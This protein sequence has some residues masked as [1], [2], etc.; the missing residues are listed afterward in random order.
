MAAV[1]G[2]E[3]FIGSHLVEALVERGSRV[4]A[5][6]QYN[7][8]NSWGWL[9]SL[10]PDVLASVEVELGDVRDIASVRALAEGADVL[11]HLAAL[12]AIPYSYRSP[13]S[14]VET[15]V[16][17]TLN[18]LE[19][20]RELNT[21]R[22]VHTSTSEVYGTARRVPIDE[23]HPLQGQSPYAATKIGAD[24][25][26]ESYHLSF[27]LPVATLR[28][29]NTYGPRQSARAVIPTIVSQVLA[30]VTTI[31]LG[32]LRPTRDFM[33]VTDT[34]HAFI[35]VGEAPGEAVV[36]NVLNAGTG[37]ETSIGS[38]AELVGRV[39]GRNLSVVEDDR[40]LRPVHS[41]VMRL[42]C[43]SSRLT[44][45]T[46]WQSSVALVD[47]I[48]ATVA[49]FTDPANLGRYRWDTYTL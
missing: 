11:Y 15:N 8:F 35:A 40:R 2:A 26:A 27:D 7:A 4:R 49:W 31:R 33:F 22:V 6:V 9:E 18:V 42:L 1:T 43:D 47:G 12:I 36:G 13:R 16:L 29:F 37:V 14:Y 38:V 24:K 41:E 25:L 46:G 34:A 45:A 17:G 5:M 48:A 19:A 32:D 3:G 10:R 28:P 20:A 21:P 39:T 44:A 30:G 23:D